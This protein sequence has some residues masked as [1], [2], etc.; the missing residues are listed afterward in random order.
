MKKLK[1]LY[2]Y[3]GTIHNEL[4]LF[5]TN[6]KLVKYTC[7]LNQWDESV[8]TEEIVNEIVERLKEL[9]MIHLI[10]EITNLSVSVPI[11]IIDDTNELF[12]ETFH[13]NMDDMNEWLHGRGVNQVRSLGEFL[14]CE[15]I[16][17]EID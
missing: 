6:G 7:V 4:E 12:I 8:Y 13:Y 1:E 5:F 9:K 3:D 11:D 2:N 15:P 14:E 10:D 17:V 16:I